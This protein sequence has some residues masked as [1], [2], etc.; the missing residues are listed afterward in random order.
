GRLFAFPIRAR[1][2]S[3][4]PVRSASSPAA[5]L[6]SRQA[7]T[8]PPLSWACPRSDAARFPLPP[9]PTSCRSA[10]G[11]R[12][13]KSFALSPPPHPSLFLLPPHG[14]PRRQPAMN[15]IGTF[16]VALLVAASAPLGVS[17]PV[18]V[19]PV[20]ERGWPGSESSASEAW[21]APPADWLPSSASP[22]A[23]AYDG[24]GGE[25][26]AAIDEYAETAEGGAPGGYGGEREAQR[27]WYEVEWGCGP[28]GRGAGRDGGG[29]RHGGRDAGE[30]GDAAAPCGDDDD[31]GDG[32]F[33]AARTRPAACA[34]LERAT[35]T[36]VERV[37]V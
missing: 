22:G 8:H 10:N 31:G 2:V 33:E 6:T 11:T 23:R 34:G 27:P 7:G 24:G 29:W 16:A 4:S 12:T 3:A 19:S 28:G 14:S 25:S 1:V 9:R 5:A 37:T 13:R 20:W 17:S 15:T 32:C 35:A 30:D 36:V 21:Q 26:E 18:S